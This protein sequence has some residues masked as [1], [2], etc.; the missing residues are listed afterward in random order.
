VTVTGNNQT[1]EQRARDSIDGLLEE[2][3]W[4]IQD[5]K[6]IDFNAGPGAAVREYAT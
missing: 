6:K 2:A 3:G 1:P 5:N 4:K